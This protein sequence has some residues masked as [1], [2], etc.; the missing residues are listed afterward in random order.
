MD[1]QRQIINL[2]IQAM[3]NAMSKIMD[4][5]R[6]IQDKFKQKNGFRFGSNDQS[7]MHLLR[8]ISLFPDDI[9]FELME[10]KN[11]IWKRY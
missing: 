6:N 8:K 10:Q 2:T 11:V 7:R 9:Q 4:E 5:Q 3:T 1:E